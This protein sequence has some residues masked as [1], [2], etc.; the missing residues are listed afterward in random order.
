MKIAVASDATN[1]SPHF[2][3]CEGFTVFEVEGQKISQQVFLPNPGHRPG[4]LPLF[5]KDQGV[6]VI[7]AGGMGAAAQELFKGNGIEVII[8]ASGSTQEVVTKY[9]EGVLESTGSVCHEHQH[10]DSCR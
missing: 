4:F 7:I 9:L 10:Q 2:G 8:G 3:H 5:L 6:K 1:V